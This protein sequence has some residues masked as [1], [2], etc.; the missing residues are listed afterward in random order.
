MEV[1]TIVNPTLRM[2][3]LRFREVKSLSQNHSALNEDSESLLPQWIHTAAN[4][5]T[6]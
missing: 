1:Q 3:K 4:H 5:F 2:G 6:T